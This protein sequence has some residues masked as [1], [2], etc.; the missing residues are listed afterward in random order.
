MIFQLLLCLIASIVTYGLYRKQN[1][2]P[3]IVLYWSVL[4]LKCLTELVG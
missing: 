4:T 3:L 2:W 1:M